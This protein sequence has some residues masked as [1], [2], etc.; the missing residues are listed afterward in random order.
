MRFNFLFRTFTF[1]MKTI[2]NGKV[3]ENSHGFFVSFGPSLYAFYGFED[4]LS[5]FGVVPEI[6]LLGQFFLFGYLF[7]FLVDVK[8]TSSR[9]RAFHAGLSSFLKISSVPG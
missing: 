5:L 3:I 2:N 8:D 7:F 6:L 9:L 4:L 1:F